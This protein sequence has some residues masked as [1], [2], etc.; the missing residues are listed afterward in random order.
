MDNHRRTEIG[1]VSDLELNSARE[2]IR[3]VDLQMRDL[4]LHRL[5][6]MRSVADWKKERGLPVEER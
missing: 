3:T 4:F 1:I 2:Q 5:D 6:A